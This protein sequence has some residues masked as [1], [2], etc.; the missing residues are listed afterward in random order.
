[1]TE[2]G[3]GIALFVTSFRAIDRFLAKNYVCFAFEGQKARKCEVN[4]LFLAAITDQLRQMV[5]RSILY[6]L[7]GLMNLRNE[8]DERSGSI[9]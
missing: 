4:A 3:L 7:K 2:K 5:Y 1:M 6:L 8:K 9:S